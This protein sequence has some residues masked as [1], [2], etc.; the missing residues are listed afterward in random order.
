MHGRIERGVV[1]GRAVDAIHW[2]VVSP[3][4]IGAYAVLQIERQYVVPAS[5]YCITEY[6]AVGI[7]LQRHRAYL[8][9]IGFQQRVGTICASHLERFQ[10]DADEIP[11]GSGLQTPILR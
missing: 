5:L 9:P 1:P 2:R 3:F 4:Q 7:E 11:F 10:A 6:I 8:A